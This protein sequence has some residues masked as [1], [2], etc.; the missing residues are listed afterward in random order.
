MK[1]FHGLATFTRA[2][3]CSFSPLLQSLTLV[4]SSYRILKSPPL[5]VDYQGE[6]A[7]DKAVA[8]NKGFAAHALR[9]FLPNR[10]YGSSGPNCLEAGGQLRL[11]SCLELSGIVTKPFNELAT[12]SHA[13]V[14]S[15]PSLPPD[16]TLVCSPVRILKLPALDINYQGEDAF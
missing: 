16:L 2:C 1:S 5:G 3:V 6:D 4:C 9:D 15:F 14:S 11:R 8:T 13:C 7:S 12:F 10:I